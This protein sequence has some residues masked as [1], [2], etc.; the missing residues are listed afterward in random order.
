M[1]YDEQEIINIR[2][3]YNSIVFGSSNENIFENGL[4]IMHGVNKMVRHFC[5]DR[6]FCW[7]N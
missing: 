7:L 3:Y 6:R 5:W 1:Y 4:E 2:L